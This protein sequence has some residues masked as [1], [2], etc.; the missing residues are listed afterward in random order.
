MASA[1]DNRLIDY[2][3]VGR[4]GFMEKGRDSSNS[5]HHLLQ[6]QQQLFY[7]QHLTSGPLH[8]SPT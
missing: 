3:A 2:V 7:T 4:R 6:L 5:T 8:I 1:D